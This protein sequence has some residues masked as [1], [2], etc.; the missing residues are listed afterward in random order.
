MLSEDLVFLVSMGVRIE[1]RSI[2]V[3]RLENMSKKLKVKRVWLSSVKM[4]KIMKKT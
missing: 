1:I 2:K 3:L 4:T